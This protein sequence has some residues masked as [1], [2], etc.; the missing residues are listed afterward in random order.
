MPPTYRPK[1]PEF[2]G[3]IE[4]T[5]PYVA[6]CICFTLVWFML[7]AVVFNYA[8]FIPDIDTQS[9]IFQSI[10]YREWVNTTW[11]PLSN[12][13]SYFIINI[14]G[15]AFVNLITLGRTQAFIDGNGSYQGIKIVLVTVP[16]L[17]L[18]SAIVILR[19][20]NDLSGY[21]VEE[22]GY[23]AYSPDMLY[24]R[25]LASHREDSLAESVIDT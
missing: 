5:W 3:D 15:W 22:E 13:V 7:G 23:D 8:Q 25:A 2:L 9:E 16:F 1:R 17:F 19:A 4:Y 18:V 20:R 21:C 24:L 6:K 10:Y 12:F 14:L 11:F